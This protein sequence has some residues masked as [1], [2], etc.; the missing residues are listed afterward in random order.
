MGAGEISVPNGGKPMD[1]YLVEAD[2]LGGFQVQ[3]ARRGGAVYRT[4]PSLVTLSDTREW[5]DEHR[6]S[7]ARLET[8]EASPPSLIDTI[9]IAVAVTIPDPEKTGA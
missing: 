1:T 7:I 4:S 5:M 6:R 8:T 3:V 2:G 9:A